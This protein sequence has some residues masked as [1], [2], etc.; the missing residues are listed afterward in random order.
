MPQHV[1]CELLN[2]AVNIPFII[3][4]KFPCIAEFF[5]LSTD[6]FVIVDSRGLIQTVNPIWQT[7]L[8]FRA[9][10]MVGRPI[11]AF[12]HPDDLE[13]SV[14][15]ALPGDDTGANLAVPLR[16]LLFF[17]RGRRRSRRWRRSRGG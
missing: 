15:T 16:E 17:E 11:M 7:V 4:T 2:E 1:P 5:D 6:L 8:G 14:Q 9:D 10:E 12:I 13:K 3:Q